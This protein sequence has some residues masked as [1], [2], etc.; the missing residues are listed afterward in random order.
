MQQKN[1]IVKKK[2]KTEPNRSETS[3]IKE[4]K[5]ENNPP[6]AIYLKADTYK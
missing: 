6:P 1:Q 4:T 2:P 5:V 3:S